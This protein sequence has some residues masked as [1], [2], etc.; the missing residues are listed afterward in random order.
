MPRN[1]Y[2][3]GPV[4]DH[5]DGTRFFI[6][7]YSSDKS[8][9]DIWRW[10]TE[11]RPKA[12]WPAQDPSPFR[13][14]PPARVSG[15]DLRVSTIGHAS[16]LIQT[17]GLSLLIDPLW[18][19]RASPVSFA[20]PK[21]VNAPGVALDDL[22]ELDAILVSHNHYD[23]LDVPTL[24]WLARHRPARVLTPLGNDAI[25]RKAVPTLRAQAFDWGARVDLGQGCA[26]HFEPAYHWS[27]RGAFDRRMALWAS[28]VITT[29]AGAIY[30]IGD[31]GYHDGA[32]FRAAREKYPP[33][34]LAIIP[35]GAYDPR[36]FMK[37]QHVDPEEAV[38]IF[39]DLGASWAM[40]H[41]WGAFRLT[42]EPIDEPPRRLAAALDAASLPRDRFVVKRP[43]EVYAV[44]PLT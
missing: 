36:W 1:P 7:G 9:A 18:S 35:I 5:F 23:H 28:F 4:S 22:P 24:R 39:G 30:H 29:P 43:G 17:Q 27:A 21:R 6:P 42:D 44:P 10:R 41:H 40:A 3:S 37:D 14:H 32:I 19:Q 13:D 20:G 25:I 2:Y 31:T 38:R 8:P 15:D 16:V 26:L 33:I 11:T 34:R 12:R